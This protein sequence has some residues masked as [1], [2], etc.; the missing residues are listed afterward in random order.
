MISENYRDIVTE[1]QYSCQHSRGKGAMGMND[2][3]F[4]LA[5]PA[6]S[7]R[8][9]GVSGT[10][11]Q[12]FAYFRAGVAYYFKGIIVCYIRIPRCGY[13]CVA[14]FSESLRHNWPHC[15]SVDSGWERIVE[16][17]VSFP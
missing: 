3:H 2:V 12:L 1:S 8:I 6:Y 11:N 7:R 5:E 13:Y 15:H 4:R 14:M 10:I 16:D 9:E 17:L